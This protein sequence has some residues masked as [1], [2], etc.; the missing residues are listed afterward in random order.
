MPEIQLLADTALST[1]I[2]TNATLAN[3]ARA[4]ALYINDSEQ[5]LWANFYLTLRY[6]SGP[7]DAGDIVAE[8]YVLPGDGEGAEIFPTG[9]DGTIGADITPQAAMFVGGF[10]CRQPNTVMDEV[11]SLTGIPLGPDGN[12][13]VIENVS[14]E[15]FDLTWQLTMKPF[16]LQTV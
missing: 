6:D 13:I 11:L 14:G 5:D 15:T 16:K 9:G 12:R 3:G 10:E 8:L 4:A 1:I 2:N 7:P